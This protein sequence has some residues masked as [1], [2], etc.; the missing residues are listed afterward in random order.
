V[1]E[2]GYNL[3]LRKLSL[4]NIVVFQNQHFSLLHTS[5]R[6]N[7]INKLHNLNIKDNQAG[8]VS[9]TVSGSEPNMRPALS[10]ASSCVMNKYDPASSRMSRSCM[11]S[12]TV[13]WMSCAS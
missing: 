9:E 8:L 5:G 7:F 12:A 3:L 1:K 4:N 2:V 6:K 11:S 13:W 10:R